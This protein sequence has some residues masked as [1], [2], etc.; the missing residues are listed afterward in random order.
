MRADVVERLYGDFN[1]LR[2]FL[3]DGQDGSGMALLPVVDEAF[4]KALCC[5]QRQATLRNA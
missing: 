1:Q 4:P 3:Q 2:G 5:L